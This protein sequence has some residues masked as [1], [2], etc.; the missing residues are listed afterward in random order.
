M[1]SCK[2]A[3][4]GQTVHTGGQS[5]SFPELFSKLCYPFPINTTNASQSFNYV[6]QFANNTIIIMHFTLD[7]ELQSASSTQY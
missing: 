2:A 6:K 1:I 7:R 3:D 5:G 4:T